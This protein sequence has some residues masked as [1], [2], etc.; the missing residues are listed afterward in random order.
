M[1][2]RRG[3]TPLADG[4][5]GDS[6]QGH[7]HGEWPTDGI[8][9]EIEGDRVVL[10]GD[11]AR[12]MDVAVGTFQVHYGVFFENALSRQLAALDAQNAFIRALFV[13]FVGTNAHAVRLADRKRA[14][15]R[16]KRRWHQTCIAR[17]LYGIRLVKKDRAVIENH[18]IGYAHELSGVV[19]CIVHGV[20]V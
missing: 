2:F 6:V 12:R 8:V 19:W 17:K 3:R 13:R 5:V 20:M 10:N 4:Q 7:F 1:P 16:E 18:A 11:N 9:V 15:A 14:C